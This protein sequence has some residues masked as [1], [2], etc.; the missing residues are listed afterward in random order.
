MPIA[1]LRSSAVLA[2]LCALVVAAT[3]HAAS[4]W[5]AG[6]AARFVSKQYGYSL[7]LPAGWSD[8]AA[9]T[10][11]PG[12]D[13]DHTASYVDSFA[14]RGR[15]LVFALGRRTTASSAAFAR[16]HGKWLVDNRPC[17]AL[18]AW[19][20]ATLSGESARVASF[21]CQGGVYG[22]TLAVKWV[23]VR[24]GLG[25]IFTQFTP[26]GKRSADEAV[27][28]RLLRGVAWTR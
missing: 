2:A 23:A 28:K 13:I 10:R 7:A 14:P 21:S 12:G 22:D 9:T 11:F 16:S 4:T 8:I 27:L 6:Q 24:R 25:L 19:R 1:R 20:K 5:T 17:R 26:D 3:T 15:R 18:G